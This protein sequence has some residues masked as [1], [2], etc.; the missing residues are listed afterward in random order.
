MTVGVISYRDHVIKEVLAMT[1]VI[2]V[3]VLTLTISWI[4]M[5]IS[6]ALKEIFEPVITKLTISTT[7]TNW[8]QNNTIPD[9]II[10]DMTF[11]YLIPL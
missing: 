2:I 10:I 4:G 1:D 5:M 9:S 7:R 8:I 6:K 11:R 3:I